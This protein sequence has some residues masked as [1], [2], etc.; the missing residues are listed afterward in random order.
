MKL[1][2]SKHDQGF[3]LLELL[4]VIAIIG[5]L[6]SIALP[7][8]LTY[9]ENAHSAQCAA[10]RHHINM[11][12]R[13]YYVQNNTSGLDIDPSWVCPSGGVYVWLVSDPDAL[14]YPEVGCSVHFAGVPTP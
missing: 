13:D 11:A 8:Y 2:T 9:R 5:A 3:T 12:E 1:L 4:M 7:S 10:N 14:G 6:A